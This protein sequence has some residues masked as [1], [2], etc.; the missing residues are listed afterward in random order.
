M[1]AKAPRPPL[2]FYR[3]PPPP[4]MLL[5]PQTDNE[6]LEALK[7]QLPKAVKSLWIVFMPD[8]VIEFR[9]ND[10][11]PPPMPGLCSPVIMFP[12]KPKF[13]SLAIVSTPC[14]C[15]RDQPVKAI[16]AFDFW[17]EARQLLFRFGLL[18]F[19]AAFWLLQVWFQRRGCVFQLWLHC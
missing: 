14:T 15:S 19:P 2:E 3:P 5:L 6:R 9:L 10:P 4:I 16:E 12:P 8:Q 13:F 18:R 11:R 1:R 7:G 17:F